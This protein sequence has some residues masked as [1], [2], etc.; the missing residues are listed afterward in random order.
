MAGHVCLTIHRHLQGPEYIARN[1]KA[2]QE[3][4]KAGILARISKSIQTKVPRGRKAKM[5]PG[6]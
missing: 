2:M 6:A 3:T 4:K 5:V 1:S